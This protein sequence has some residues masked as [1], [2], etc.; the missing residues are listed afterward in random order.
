M[1]HVLP[2]LYQNKDSILSNNINVVLSNIESFLSTK[3]Y[4]VLSHIKK[5]VKKILSSFNIKKK[6]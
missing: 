2:S 5:I 3:K 6:I 1:D 4:I